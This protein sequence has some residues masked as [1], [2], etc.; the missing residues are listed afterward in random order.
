MLINLLKTYAF[1]A[2][3]PVAAH[4]LGLVLKAFI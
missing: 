3:I 1:I 4:L 2:L